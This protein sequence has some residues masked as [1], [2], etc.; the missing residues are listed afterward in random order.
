MQ[1]SGTDLAG[2]AG[3]VP[4]LVRAV[5]SFGD[6]SGGGGGQSD[7][8][9]HAG[10]SAGRPDLG[11]TGGPS[12]GSVR[13]LRHCQHGGRLRRPFSL[14]GTA[15]HP[16]GFCSDCCASLRPFR[17]S[18]AGCRFGSL[19]A[20]DGYGTG[21]PCA[22]FGS[23]LA[24]CPSASS[25]VH[26]AA[27]RL[28]D[29]AVFTAIARSSSSSASRSRS[30]GPHRQARTSATTSWRPRSRQAS[31]SQPRGRG[32]SPRPYPPTDRATVH[33]SRKGEVRPPPSGEGESP[34]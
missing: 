23:Q 19:F 33:Q 30:G 32:R 4:L 11:P 20:D 5:G 16:G 8:L 25:V 21:S 15:A 13:C 7:L 14:G 3:Q 28:R 22:A 27:D 34:Q 12:V 9:L 17:A 2:G 10:H 1:S 26:H 18:P 24:V 29:E 31:R 6:A